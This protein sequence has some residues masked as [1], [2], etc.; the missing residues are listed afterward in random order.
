MVYAKSVKASRLHSAVLPDSAKLFDGSSFPQFA[1]LLLYFV[2]LNSGRIR[3]NTV[4]SF[5]TWL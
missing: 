1:D 2:E 3:T 5:T 4:V